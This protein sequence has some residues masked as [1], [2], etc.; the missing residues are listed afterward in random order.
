MLCREQF[1]SKFFQNSNDNFRKTENISIDEKIPA[2]S[3]EVKN[4]GPYLNGEQNFD[5][6][7]RQIN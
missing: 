6:D 3:S 5:L 7:T 1:S 4:L 2:E